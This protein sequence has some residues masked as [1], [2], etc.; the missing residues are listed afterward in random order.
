MNFLEPILS[1][2]PIA[3]VRHNHALEHATLQILAKKNPHQSAAGY[4][5]ARGFWVLG[6]VSTDDLQAAVD[7]AINRLRAGERALAI[8]PNCGTNFAT[9]GVLGGGLAWLATL[10]E[11]HSWEAKVER[12]PL[13]IILITLATILAQPLGMKM[14]AI[15]TTDAEIGDLKVTEITRLQRKDAPMHRVKTLS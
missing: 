9:A 14:Q 10:G 2:P 1:W 4:S 5:D 7:E 13:M 15:L 6:D 12:L 8:H 11:R 3:R